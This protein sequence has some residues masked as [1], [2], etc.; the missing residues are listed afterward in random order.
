MKKSILDNNSFIMAIAIV[1]S[2]VAWMVVSYSGNTAITTTIRDVKVVIEAADANLQ[3]YDLV[4]IGDVDDLTVDIEVTGP[5]A[6][7][8]NMDK[9]ELIVNARL[10]NVTGAGEYDLPLEV[11]DTKNRSI[12]YGAVRPDTVKVRF[13]RMITRTLPIKLEMSGVTIPDGY[14]MDEE[15]VYP[16]EVQVS[17]PST[18]IDSIKTANVTLAFDEPL[19]KSIDRDI[20][21]VLRDEYGSAVDSPYFTFNNSKVRVSVPVLKKKTVPVKFEYVNVP[22][23]FNTEV[24]KYSLSPTEVEIAGPEDKLSTFNEIH[25][26][27]IDIRNLAPD[28]NFFYAINLP[29]NFISVDGTSDANLRF[30]PEGF[31]YRDFSIDSE[32]IRVINVSDDYEVTIQSKSIP[33]VTVYGPAE[34][35]ELVTAKDLV[36]QVDMGQI[37]YKL[38]QVTVPVEIILNDNETCWAYG[39]HYTV[40]AT[41]KA[42]Q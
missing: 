34:D 23:G 31:D 21:V 26:D 28:V 15:H 6:T 27:Y 36:A 1:V 7:V 16:T 14:L 3:R 5:R 24:L 38:G 40:R 9:D 39:T 29:D 22:S 8:G 17:G 18:E 42:K 25:L 11:Q 30:N 2:V 12:E 35:L 37:D 4:A 10:N 19:T 13:D 32:R 20:N 41:I 33:G